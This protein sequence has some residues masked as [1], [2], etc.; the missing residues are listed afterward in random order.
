M[1]PHREGRELREALRN[2]RTSVTLIHVSWQFFGFSRNTSP[3][4][5]RQ[6]DWLS[7][8]SRGAED[9]ERILPVGGC[10]AKIISLRWDWAAGRAFE[11]ASVA[12]AN[13]SR[14]TLRGGLAV[15]S[16][17]G[18]VLRYPRPLLPK[19]VVPPSRFSNA[20]RGPK[21]IIGKVDA[22]PAVHSSYWVLGVIGF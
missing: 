18:G 16:Q 22:D 1:I 14:E 17:G 10:S 7:S 19:T 6:Q 4:Q 21:L 13:R 3:I 15:G 5:E 8:L 12:L 9:G 11:S 20:P 2:A